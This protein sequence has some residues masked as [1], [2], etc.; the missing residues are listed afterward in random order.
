MLVFAGLGSSIRARPGTG[1]L[2]FIRP[3]IAAIVAGSFP[4]LFPKLTKPGAGVYRCR[5]KFGYV[6]I[7][8]RGTDEGGWVVVDLDSLRYV[9]SLAEE[10]HFG[11]A[12]Q[13][14][15]I[16][17]QAFGRRIQRLEGEL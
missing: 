11:R 14:H 4:R 15:Y 16:V 9:V 1:P 12:A 5:P 7:V 6:R 2:K 3:W 13:R 10:L 17:P 8:E